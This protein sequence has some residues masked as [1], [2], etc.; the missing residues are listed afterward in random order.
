MSAAHT[1][2]GI[3][4]AWLDRGLEDAIEPELPIIDPHHHFWD[5]GGQRYLGPELLADLATGHNVQATVFVECMS[6]YREAG[7]EALRPVGET[8]FVASMAGTVTT[9][10]GRICDVA[11][12]I[13]GFADLTLG[14]AVDEVLAAHVAAGRGRFRGIRHASQWEG[15]GDVVTFRNPP[16][17]LLGQP[18]FRAGFARLAAH[19]LAFD[20]WLYHPQI[21]ELVDLARAFPETRIVLD[22]VGGPLRIGSYARE[23]DAVFRDWARAIRALGTCPNVVV[24]LGGFGMAA[25]SGFDFHL[26]LAPPS[27]AQLADAWRP[28]T[29]TCIDAFGPH[30]TMFESNYPVDKVSY[31]YGVMWNAFKRLAAGC[32]SAEKA[33]LFSGTAAR[34]YR[35]A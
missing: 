28:F 31:S 32:S 6:M 30:R 22:H 2:P 21:D 9:G 33:D 27:S 16:P 23:L 12:G 5:R 11:A 35:I 3:D 8:E 19:D 10:A 20:A 24:K 29:D 17:G 18:A 1:P 7:P 14:A 34:T 13:V 15:R 26:W 25:T 4:Q